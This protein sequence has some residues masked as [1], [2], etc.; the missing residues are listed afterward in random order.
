M[1]KTLRASGGRRTDTDM[2]RGSIFWHLLS[3]AFPLLV[4]NIF[5][6][7]YNT[8]DSWVVG[9]FVSKEAFS[10]VGTVGPIVNMLIGAFSG[11]ASG[12][13]VV[14]SQY[15][16]AKN[17]EKVQN[18]VHTA[19]ALTAIMTV[20]FTFVGILMTPAMLNL[21][22]TPEDV[23]P[24]S[25]AYLTIYFGGMIGLLFYNMGAGILRAVGDSRHPF[26]FLVVSAIINI[27]L[28]LVFVLVFDMGVAGVAWATVVAQAVSAL[29]TVGTLMRSNSGIR[30]IPKKLRVHM[31]MLKKI[32]SVG[33]PAALQ[34]AVTSFSN[35][36][37][38][39][40]INQFGTA[41]MAGWTAYNKIDQ[42]IFMPMQS[43]AMAST[44][45][46]GQNLGMGQVDRAKKGVRMTMAMATL[47]TVVISGLVILFRTPL[48]AFF[49]SDADVISYGT[50]FLKWMTPFYV[51]CC[52]NQIYSG[53]LR[54]SGDSRAPMVI[55]L[56][57]F[58]LFRQVYL[59]VVSN[60]IAN[61]ILPLAMGY[62]AGWLLCSLLTLIYY[63]TRADFGKNRLVSDSEVQGKA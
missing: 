30:L 42:L 41:C 49:N 26:Y 62:P 59:F 4:G 58:V 18:A 47:S 34:M 43:L 53:A 17:D 28:D 50:L 6:Q 3:F 63:H 8:V 31:E 56:L 9:N 51:L 24:E 16:G 36:F 55:M 61:E 32:V 39:S 23:F 15:Y 52:V 60:F 22:R 12:A 35:V 19:I 7:F 54:G 27:V 5:Q 2:T 46:V 14:I 10:A 45:F 11:L 57:S 21:M 25:S 29:L 33:I 20:V 40:Y 48:V 13:G 37:V 38:Q 1:Q 44:T